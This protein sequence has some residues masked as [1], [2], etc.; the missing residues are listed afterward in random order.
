MVEG[1]LK[2]DSLERLLRTGEC[3]CEC[4]SE[5]AIGSFFSPG[6]DKTAESA[7]VSVEYEGVPV[8]LHFHGYGSSAK[9]TRREVAEW[10]AKSNRVG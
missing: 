4:G 3:W 2:L 1:P 5:T 7:V 8:F 9:N 10:R 6:H